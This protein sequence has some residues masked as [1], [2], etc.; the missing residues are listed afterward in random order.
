MMSSVH[1]RPLGLFPHFIGQLPL[2]SLVSLLVEHRLVRVL[3]V[4]RGV[5]WEVEVGVAAV[6]SR[7]LSEA[8]PGPSAI[9]LAAFIPLLRNSLNLAVNLG[10]GSKSRPSKQRRC[11]VYLVDNF[12]GEIVV[13]DHSFANYANCPSA[14]W[15]YGH[16]FWKLSFLTDKKNFW[17][18]CHFVPF[19]NIDC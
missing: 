5:F 9:C 8:D 2:H 12:L 11:H 4:L 10:K 13:V 18:I 15:N 14:N 19:K 17:M 7:K 16:L 3:S 6:H 1:W